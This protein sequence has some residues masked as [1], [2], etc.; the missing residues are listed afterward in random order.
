MAEAIFSFTRDDMRV[1]WLDD[2][3]K[4]VFAICQGRYEDARP[5]QKRFFAFCQ[6]LNAFFDPG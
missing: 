1:E 6:G 4:G 2:P 5:W 3:G